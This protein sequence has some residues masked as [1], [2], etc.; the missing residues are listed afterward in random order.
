MTVLSHVLQSL[1]LAC[2]SPF[3]MQSLGPEPMNVF[4]LTRA[5]IEI[6]SVT[7]EEEQV[8]EYLYRLPFRSLCAAYKGVVEKI[9][10]EPHRNNV[11]AAFGTPVVTLSTHM[12]TVPPLFI[13]YREDEENILGTRRLRHQRHHCLH[14]Y[15]GR[16]WLLEAG[17]RDFGL[18]FVVGEE[19]ATALA[20]GITRRRLRAARNTS[21]TASQQRIS[22]RSAPKAR[23]VM[24]W[25]RRAAWR[26][27]RIRN[28]ANRPSK[29]C[30]MRC[31]LFLRGRP[32]PVDPILGQEYAQHRH[33]SRRARAQ[34]DSR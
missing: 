16:A 1:S 5:L 8:G 21:S 30:S 26:T 27:R 15:C 28:W 20:Q 23:C 13:P 17:V 9:E 3:T 12:D 31:R 6:P 33:H 4:E 7:P 32:L 34:C 25:W 29:C 10:V 11:F 14:A 19:R 2:S 18:L 24:R 22:W